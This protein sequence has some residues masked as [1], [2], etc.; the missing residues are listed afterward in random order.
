[1][2]RQ[3][4]AKHMFYYTSGSFLSDQCKM[5]LE[6]QV[7]LNMC[8]THH[9]NVVRNN[10]KGILPVL[11]MGGTVEKKKLMWKNPSCL[12]KVVPL[13]IST[14]L[15]TQHFYFLLKKC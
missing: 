2:K 3:S 8:S 11:N 13:L 15:T 6:I 7:V 12:Y 14:L 9:Y 4:V 10:S 1:M 5:T